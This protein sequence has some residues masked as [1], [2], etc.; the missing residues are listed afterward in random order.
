MTVAIAKT[1]T[2]KPFVGLTP[3]QIGLAPRGYA[4]LFLDLGELQ[5]ISPQEAIDRLEEMGY[6]P[7]LRYEETIAG[8][9]CCLL[10]KVVKLADVP[11]DWENEESPFEDIIE[12]LYEI[13]GSAVRSRFSPLKEVISLP[14]RRA[15]NNQ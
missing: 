4:F 12:T 3:Y 10:L 13:F 6:K 5:E 2:T 1:T 8:L 15:A 14:E 11:F 7:S 9:R